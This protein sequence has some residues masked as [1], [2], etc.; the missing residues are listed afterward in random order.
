[1]SP[2][3]PYL[4]FQD[5]DASLRFLTEG[6]GFRV[7]TEQRGEDGALIHAELTRGEAVVMGGPGDVVHGAAPGIYL[8]VDDVD[9][10]YA[11]ATGLG[12]S[13][14]YPPED[15]EWGTRRA[16]FVDPDGH[17]WT[18]GTYQPGQSWG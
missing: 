12:A 2:I 10:L 4:T 3:V 5:G 17:E 15:T 7:V 18:V 16:R 13:G 8:V 6:L 9:A 14:G 1:M 11:K